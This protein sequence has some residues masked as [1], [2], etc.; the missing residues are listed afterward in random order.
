MVTRP[1]FRSRLQYARCKLCSDME[2]TSCVS[3]VREGSFRADE[4]RLGSVIVVTGS[5]SLSILY[6]RCF[7]FAI[8]WMAGW[9]VVWLTDLLAVWL[10]G[11]LVD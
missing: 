3:W 5:C 2:E 11:W 10:V 1:V 7:L 4:A 9:L 8:C 6:Y